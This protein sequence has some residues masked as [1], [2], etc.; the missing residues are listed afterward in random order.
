M[1]ASVLVG[2]LCAIAIGALGVVAVR[3]KTADASRRSK[4]ILV[5]RRLECRRGRR[6]GG[7]SPRRVVKQISN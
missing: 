2:L 1:S 4:A 5:A 3:S 7:L 6:P